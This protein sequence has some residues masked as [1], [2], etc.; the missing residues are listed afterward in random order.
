MWTVLFTV[1]RSKVYRKFVIDGDKADEKNNRRLN[2]EMKVRLSVWLRIWNRS[3]DFHNTRIAFQITGA[4]AW[5]PQQPSG[6][7]MEKQK[8]PEPNGPMIAVNSPDSTV[9]SPLCAAPCSQL[10]GLLVPKIRRTAPCS[11][12]NGLLVPKIRAAPPERLSDR[13]F[14]P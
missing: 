8:F 5:A 1:M 6:K 13:R 11:P 10:N 4:A 9:K 2:S 14:G 7:L 12:P 3:E